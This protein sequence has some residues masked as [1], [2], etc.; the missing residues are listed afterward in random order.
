MG[1]A[2]TIE[3]VDRLQDGGPLR[4]EVDGRGLDIGRDQHLDWTLPDPSRFISGKHCEVRFRDGAYYL[5]DVSSNGTF[6][7]GADFRMESPHRLH[8]GDRLQIGTY[9]VAVELDGAARGAAAG[10]PAV[11]MSEISGDPWAAE[12]AAAPP[13]DRRDF[14]PASSQKASPDF[15]DWALQIDPHRPSWQEPAQASAPPALPGEDADWL[16][17]PSR[18]APSEAPPPARRG[19]G[20]RPPRP[21]SRADPPR[22]SAGRSRRLPRPGAS[23]PRVPSARPRA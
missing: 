10:Q 19:A 9:I 20:P 4:V 8:H 17:G 1:L 5:H 2:L 13:A 14:I 12:G 16:R 23:R 3:N 6:L 15:L 18:T 22:R 21:R 7:N 11:Q